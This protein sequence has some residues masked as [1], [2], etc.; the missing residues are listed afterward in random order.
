MYIYICIYI[1]IYIYNIYMHLCNDTYVDQ[2]P[3]K[4]VHCI[5]KCSRYNMSSIV[6]NNKGSPRLPTPK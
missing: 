5:P 1:Y 3:S 4:T 2:L 6:C